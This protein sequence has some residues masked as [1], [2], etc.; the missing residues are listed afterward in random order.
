MLDEF[1]AIA[2]CH[3]KHAVR[4]LKRGEE[5][6]A[7]SVPKGQAHLRRGRKGGTDRGMGGIGQAMREET[8][9]GA[10]QHGGVTGA[11][12]SS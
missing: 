7:R 8:E 11:T 3:R 1:V 12:R 5:P 9:G 10:A 2:G 4:L 6:T